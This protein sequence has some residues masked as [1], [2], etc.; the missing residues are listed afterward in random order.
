MILPLCNLSIPKL[1]NIG[2]S[3]EQIAEALGLS[4]EEV[5]A[6]N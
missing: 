4:V 2:L 5:Q 6:I 1:L 3:V